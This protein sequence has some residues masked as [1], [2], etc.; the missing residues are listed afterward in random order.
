MM[1]P[2]KCEVCEESQ[3]KYKC[4][5]CLIPYC[6]LAC[7]KKHK[8]TPCTKPEPITEEKI[9]TPC[10]KP[11]P[12]TVENVD[13]G[14]IIRKPCYVDE[15]SEV[16]QKSKL[17]SIASSSEIRDSIKDEKLQK[18][19]QN[20]DSSANPEYELDKA[21]EDDEFRFLTEKILS[22]IGS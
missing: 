17:Q 12:L 19:I 18:L 3:S 14:S 10:T 8:E 6:S 2:R 5:S 15:A 20:I 1:G 21:M 13:S 7:F 9:E 16:L 4:P 11:E 22:T